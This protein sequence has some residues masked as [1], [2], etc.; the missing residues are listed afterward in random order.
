ML[1]Q[2][3]GC[4]LAAVIVLVI[5]IGAIAMIIGGP[6]LARRYFWWIFVTF[7]G[8]PARWALRH[9]QRLARQFLRWFGHQL[10][11]LAR[12]LGRQLLRLAHWLLVQLGHLAH[13]LALWLGRISWRLAHAVWAR[14]TT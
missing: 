11:L 14:L 9:G 3:L 4:L 1:L 7:L 2:Q 13:R 8:V 12:Y 10:A 5:Q 6:R